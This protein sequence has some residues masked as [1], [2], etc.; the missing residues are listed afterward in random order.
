MNGTCAS[1]YG[2]WV[3][4]REDCISIGQPQSSSFCSSGV[5]LNHP[6]PTCTEP[7]NGGIR[8]DGDGDGGK[9]SKSK[10]CKHPYKCD[11]KIIISYVVDRDMAN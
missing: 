4:T 11:G 1:E 10:A 2:G 6:Q 5:W 8:S 7:I 9:Q 3:Y